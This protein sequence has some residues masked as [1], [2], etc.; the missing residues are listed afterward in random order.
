MERESRELLKLVKKI[1]KLAGFVFISPNKVL[2]NY[3]KF[4]V[5]VDSAVGSC[6]VAKII[7]SFFSSYT[8]Y[9]PFK[10]ANKGNSSN[11]KE[12]SSWCAAHSNCRG[13]NAQQKSDCVREI[14]FYFHKYTITHIWSN[15]GKHS[16]HFITREII[17]FIGDNLLS[18]MF[19]FI[20][21]ISWL[22]RGI[23]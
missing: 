1:L 20:F 12:N 18:K 19:N 11:I 10:G 13:N 6:E 21:N 14:Y 5:A 9:K 22:L 8:Q 3:T 15:S 7:F 16:G 23:S 4:E 17:G 2:K